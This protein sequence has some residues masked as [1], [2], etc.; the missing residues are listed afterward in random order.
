MEEIVKK[1]LL[2]GLLFLGNNLA[3]AI[4]LP[5]AVETLNFQKVRELL[6]SG[7]YT[8][9]ERAQALEKSEL[10]IRQHNTTIPVYKNVKSWARLACFSAATYYAT[11]GI[12]NFVKKI[13]ELDRLPYGQHPSVFELLG[14]VLKGYTSVIAA[15]LS[16]IYTFKAI[17][18]F[19]ICHN[20]HYT[21]ALSISALLKGSKLKPA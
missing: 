9:Q 1:I 10:S 8:N 4:N 6:T 7:S 19:N 15:P 11:N 14:A 21:T 16:A 17:Q 2:F 13:I 3:R 18:S 20:P 5:Q 12:I